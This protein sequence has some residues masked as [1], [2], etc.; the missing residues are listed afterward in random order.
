MEYIIFLVALTC[1]NPKFYTLFE[2]E[3]ANEGLQRHRCENNLIDCYT[4]AG[5]FK[6]CIDNLRELESQHSE[7]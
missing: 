5:N 7:N 3:G 2:S 1:T 6:H 4:Y